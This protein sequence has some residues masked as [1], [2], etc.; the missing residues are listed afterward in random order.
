MLVEVI[1]QASAHACRS[2]AVPGIRH[3]VN[4]LL[5]NDF[6]TQWQLRA[7]LTHQCPT[8]QQKSG[9]FQNWRSPKRWTPYKLSV[10]REEF[11][12]ACAISQRVQQSIPK[13]SRQ[14]EQ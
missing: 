5:V 3:L 8:R 1:A 6:R 4:D 13:P 7:H 10:R 14:I 9:K 2:A 12:P 11:S